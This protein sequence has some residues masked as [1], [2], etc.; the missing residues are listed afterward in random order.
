LIALASWAK[1][2]VD[3]RLTID[4]KTLGLDPK[5]AVLRAPA[6]EKFQEAAEFRPGDVIRVEPGKGWLLVLR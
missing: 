4:W 3:I 1:D 2:P 5:K 6:I